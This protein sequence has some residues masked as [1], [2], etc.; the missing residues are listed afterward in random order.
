MTSRK[1][2]RKGSIKLKDTLRKSNVSVKMTPL[3]C[4]NL[5]PGKTEQ[6]IN[7]IFSFSVHLYSLKQIINVLLETECI[8]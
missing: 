7:S 2:R 5:S 6:D 8:S 4:L 1:L 3:T